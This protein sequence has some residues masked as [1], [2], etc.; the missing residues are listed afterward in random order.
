MKTTIKC[1]R[2][3]F[4]KH[5]FYIN[6]DGK[7]Y[8][9]FSQNYRKGVNNLFSQG[10]LL[11]NAFNKKNVNKDHSILKTMSKL[12][13]Y[14]RYI[15]KEYNVQILNNTKDKIEKKIFKKPVFNINDYELDELYSF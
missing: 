6:H 2:N 1:T 8:F 5:D 10:V 9:L 11:Q 12:K 3:K 13:P 14:I 15:E 4:G 7:Q